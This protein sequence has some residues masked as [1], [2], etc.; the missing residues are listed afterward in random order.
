MSAPRRHARERLIHAQRAPALCAAIHQNLVR[1]FPEQDLALI[2]WNA[3]LGHLHFT[4]RLRRLGGR[5]LSVRMVQ[6]WRRDA[7]CP[8]LRGTYIIG[9]ALSP[10][11]TTAFALS[12]W[13]LSR[14]ESATYVHYF[15]IARRD[16]DMPA[17][18]HKRKAP[19]TTA[20]TVEV[21]VPT[22]TSVLEPA[23][24]VR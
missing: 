9:H 14:I 2:G 16:D 1:F 22:G 21:D 24:A 13:V 12:S 18:S 4:L 6:R 7:N 11:M 15:S 23:V 5:P 17:R 10:P 20:R 3:I 19:P 8:I